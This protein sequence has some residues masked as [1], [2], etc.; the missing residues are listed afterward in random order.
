MNISVIIP[1]YN[2]ANKIH[3]ALKAL[4]NQSYSKF[5]VIVIIDGSIDNTKE[6]IVNNKSILDIEIIEQTNGGRSVAK[7]I[8]AEIAKDGLLIFLDDDMIPSENFIAEHLKHHQLFPNSILTGSYERHPEIEKTDFGKYSLYLHTK[9]TQ[10]LN[11]LKV[12]EPMTVE[13][14]FIQSGNYSMDKFIFNKIGGFDK[15]L[16]DAEDYLL[17]VK[18][19]RAQ[20]K[21]FYS[22]LAWAYHYEMKTCKSTIK[23]LRQYYSSQ[24][25]LKEIDEE[26]ALKSKYE[27]GT[28]MGVKQILFKCFTIKFFIYLIDD[29]FFVILPSKIRFKLYDIVITA[30]GVFYPTAVKL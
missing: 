26:I 1:T 3:R 23:R 13:N 17:S 22:T 5:G 12:G 28:P 29:G 18:A 2:G 21:M 14:Y 20:I 6:I 4:S 27:S 30:N 19:N 8:G 9:W 7:N 10:N 11:L 16:N 15:R 24:K 25:Q